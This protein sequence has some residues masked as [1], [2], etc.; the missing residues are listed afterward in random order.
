MVLLQKTKQINILFNNI[1][2]TVAGFTLVSSMLL[3]VFNGIIRIF[4]TP[5]GAVIE[6]VSWGAAIATAF[7]LGST[8]ISKGH[9]YID[10]LFK[11]FPKL[12][13]QIISAILIIVSIVFFTTVIYQLFL[14]GLTLKESGTMST[15]LGF[16]FYPLVMIVSFGFI[17]LLTTLIL[18]FLEV[19][20]KGGVTS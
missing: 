11:K 7:S 8:Q 14:Y 20:F 17:G 1:L 16:K 19:F 15:T 5:F 2:L 6:V 10:L 12:L 4:S 9:V 13:Q 18:E 3:I